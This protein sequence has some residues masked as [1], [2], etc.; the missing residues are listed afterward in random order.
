ME[1]ISIDYGYIELTINN[2]PNKVIKILP[3]DYGIISRFD[4]A[5]KKIVE[6][7]ESAKG[8]EIDAAG[9]PIEQFEKTAEIVRNINNQIC[10][11]IDYI[12]GSNISEIAFDGQSPLALVG[13]VPLFEQFLKAIFPIINK[14]IEKEQKKSQ[15]RISKYTEQVK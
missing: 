2:D 15:K 7:A 3:S 11:Q 1:N 5:Y 14:A 4:E 6:V 9:K 12:F 8:I 13:G 10:E